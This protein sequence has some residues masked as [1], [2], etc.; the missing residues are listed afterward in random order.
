M[1]VSKFL[2]AMPICLRLFLHAS[3]Y[4]AIMALLT[5]PNSNIIRIPI[6]AMT[7]RSSMRV[8]PRLLRTDGNADIANSSINKG[9]QR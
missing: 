5:A 2:T 7:T 1:L 9:Q 4:A 6:I 3:V 8:K